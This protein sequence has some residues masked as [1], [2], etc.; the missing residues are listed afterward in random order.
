M[1]SITKQLE[2]AGYKFFKPAMNLVLK[3]TDTL[4]QKRVKDS[5]GNTKYFINAWYY[6]ARD[7]HG[8]HLNEGLQFEAQLREGTCKVDELFI[9][10]SPHTNDRKVAEEVI[11]KAWQSLDMGFVEGKDGAFSEK[12]PG[13]VLK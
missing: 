9:D 4:Y 13:G 2:D 5:E 10:V 12:A 3:S 11:E 7:I 6:P 8:H 1:T